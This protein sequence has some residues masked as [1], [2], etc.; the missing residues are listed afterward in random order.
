MMK[1]Q[2][3]APWRATQLLFGDDG[4]VGSFMSYP[5]E[6]VALSKEVFA[7]AFMRA[8]VYVPNEK[9]CLWLVQ[10]VASCRPPHVMWT[11]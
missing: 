9:A 11:A 3:L 6:T 8:V 5:V 7:F 1:Q 10:A 2:D 4:N